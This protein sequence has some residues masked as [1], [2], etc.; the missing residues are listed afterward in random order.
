M[1]KEVRTIPGRFYTVRLS[2]EGT[3]HAK[4]AS[5]TLLL[6]ASVQAA[7]QVLVQAYSDCFVVSDNAAT[8]MSVKTPVTVGGAGVSVEHFDEHVGKIGTTTEAGHLRHGG[9][10]VTAENGQ[11]RFKFRSEHSGF[12]VDG[13]NAVYANT[14][15]NDHPA[16]GAIAPVATDTAGKFC[17]PFLTLEKTALLE[18]LLT[19]KDA[20]L[21]AIGATA[22]E[23]AAIMDAAEAMAIAEAVAV[24]AAESEPGEIVPLPAPMNPQD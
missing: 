6:L 17:V 10:G 20:L 24:A 11:L 8:V 21:A 4:L 16:H 13:D 7:G 2:G 1:S 14:G 5:G 15:T 9:V 22:E 12:E 3:V 18:V 23:A 19:H